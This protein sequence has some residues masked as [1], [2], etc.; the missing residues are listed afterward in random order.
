MPSGYV[1]SYA[2]FIL[3]FRK[4]H[5]ESVTK[6]FSEHRLDHSKK[7]PYILDEDKFAT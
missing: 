4:S 6:F 3:P 2:V 1:M 5:I 7:K